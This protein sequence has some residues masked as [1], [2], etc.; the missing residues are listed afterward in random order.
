MNKRYV[1]VRMPLKAHDNLV[2]KKNK[3][4]LDYQKLT[5]KRKKIPMTKLLI[6]M[7]ESPI[8][9]YDNKEFIKQFKRKI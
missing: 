8:Y 5:G 6:K 2:I 9:F 4:E 3:M 1:Q 7:S